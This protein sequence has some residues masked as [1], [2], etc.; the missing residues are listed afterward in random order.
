MESIHL[1]PGSNATYR[2]IIDCRLF[3]L[4]TGKHCKSFPSINITDLIL[5]LQYV[6]TFL[7]TNQVYAGYGCMHFYLI[8]QLAYDAAIA[9]SL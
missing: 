6:K 8:I 3:A 5:L 7:T 4:S 1:C 9:Y 2:K